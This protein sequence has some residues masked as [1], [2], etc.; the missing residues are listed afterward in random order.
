[1]GMCQGGKLPNQRDD[2]RPGPLLFDALSASGHLTSKAF[3][4]HLDSFYGMNYVDF[5]P[6]KTESLEGDPGYLFVADGF[7]W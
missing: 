1:M 7:F 6:P 4:F 3:S 5:G 2:F